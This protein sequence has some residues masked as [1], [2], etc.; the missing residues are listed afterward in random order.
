MDRIENLIRGLDPVRAERESSDSPTEIIA[1]PAGNGQQEPGVTMNTEP[2]DSLPIVGRETG[3]EGNDAFS[4]DRPV[5]VP[6][7][8]RRRTAMILAGAAAAAVVAGAV[9]VGGSLGA[10]SPLPA[11]TT[12]PA[13]SVEPTQQRTAD[14]SPSA[15][16]TAEPTAEPSVEPSGV[17]TG[18]PADEGCRVQD[19]DRVMEQ[20]SDFMSLTP[21]AADPSHYAVVGCTDDWMAMEL[22]DAGFEANPQDGGNAWYYV[23]RRVDGQWLVETA[24]Y[25]ALTKWEFLPVVEGSTPQEVMDQQFID[26]GIPVELRPELVGDGPGASEA[27]ALR[28]IVQADMAL[29]FELPEG[30][31]TMGAAVSPV[32]EVGVTNADGDP[33]MTIT[34]TFESGIGGAC[35][36]DPVPITEISS[37][38]VTLQLPSGTALDTKF[39]YRVIETA[40]G[41]YGSAALVLA[42]EPASGNY[43]MLYNVISTPEMGLFSM[44]SALMIGPDSLGSLHNHANLEQAQAYVESAEF[45]EMLAIAQSLEITG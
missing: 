26:T 40:D 23:A 29:Q 37:T 5:V 18:P 1:L 31:S 16:P 38:P 44:A 3:N 15:E 7:R 28:E 2:I 30:W 34:R 21:F 42:T 35:S 32:R 6:L 24:G 36:G 39:V 43:C 14:P 20:G 9:V 4:D 22:T 12:N 17:P 8:R 27:G 33:V 41:V 45:E 11:G 25:S 19:V 13:P 10:E